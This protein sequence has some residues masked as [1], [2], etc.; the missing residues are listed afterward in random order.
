[1]NNCKYVSNEQ[2]AILSMLAHEE[3]GA[4]KYFPPHYFNDGKYVEKLGFSLENN[5]LVFKKIITEH[6]NKLDIV[7]YPLPELDSL[8]Q[9][10]VTGISKILETYPR[11]TILSDEDGK[12]S[13]ISFINV[14]NGNQNVVARTIVD[15][16]DRLQVLSCNDEIPEDSRLSNSI[17]NTLDMVYYLESLNENENECRDIEKLIQMLDNMSDKPVIKSK[18]RK[19]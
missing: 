6:P 18:Q 12:D 19:K 13:I 3:R 15:E 5:L 16:Y 2:M 17:R 4:F 7:A 14:K 11:I 9:F 10:F 8:V 1:M